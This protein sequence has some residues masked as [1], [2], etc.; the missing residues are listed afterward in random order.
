MS[1]PFIYGS[2]P[3]ANLLSTSNE[4]V[5]GVEIVQRHESRRLNVSIIII[6]SKA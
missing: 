5:M 4:Q 6:I 2:A 3:M 1:P